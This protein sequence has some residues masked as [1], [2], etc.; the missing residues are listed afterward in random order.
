M[1]IFRLDVYYLDA[2]TCRSNHGHYQSARARTTK[3][4]IEKGYNRPGTARPRLPRSLSVV[5]DG[6]STALDDVDVDVDLHPHALEI[7]AIGNLD[8]AESVNQP[9][10]GH[11]THARWLEPQS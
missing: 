6:T 7:L 2:E 11:R 10:Q 3:E 1:C 8:E 9:L 5:A 4:G